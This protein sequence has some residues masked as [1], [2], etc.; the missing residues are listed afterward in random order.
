MYINIMNA[1]YEEVMHKLATQNNAR[2]PTLMEG[3]PYSIL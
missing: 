1:N 2:R 3:L